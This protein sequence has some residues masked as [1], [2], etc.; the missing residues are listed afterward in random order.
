[1]YPA[2]FQE[3]QEKQCELLRMEQ[4]L[5]EVE[6]TGGMTI[7]QSQLHGTDGDTAPI[8]QSQLEVLNQVVFT[9]M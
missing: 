8:T 6:E 7:T 1:M 3:H 9:G 4:Q 5:A 2:L